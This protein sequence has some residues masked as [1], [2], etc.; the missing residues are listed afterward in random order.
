MDEQRLDDLLVSVYS[1]SV[2]IRGVALKTCQKQWTIV[3][4][5]RKRSGISVVKLR[6]DDHDYFTFLR[7]FHTSK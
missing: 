2:Q 6:H 4:G 1:C 3:K 7:V 5:D